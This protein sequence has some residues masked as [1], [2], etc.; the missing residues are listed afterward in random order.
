MFTS[1]LLV[2]GGIKRS[3]GVWFFQESIPQRRLDRCVRSAG[4]LRLGLQ[5]CKQYLSQFFD[6]FIVT[7]SLKDLCPLFEVK[8]LLISNYFFSHAFDIFYLFSWKPLLEHELKMLFHIFLELLLNLPVLLVNCA[9]QYLAKKADLCVL[10]LILFNCLHDRASPLDYQ[11]LK[12]IPLIEK[13]KHV[14]L[15]SLTGLLVSLALLV[16]FYLRN[17]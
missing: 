2:A 12:T 1:R 16:V 10:V 6:V 3:F 17:K 14:L 13:G 9:T 11:S 4:L 8:L 7:K 15:N 5:W